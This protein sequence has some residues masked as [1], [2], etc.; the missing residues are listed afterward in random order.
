MTDQKEKL[1]KKLNNSGSNL[2]LRVIA[3][4]LRLNIP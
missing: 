1:L 2:H 3:L 4:V